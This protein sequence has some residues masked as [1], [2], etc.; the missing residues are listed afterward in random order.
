MLAFQCLVHHLL[1][2]LGSICLPRCQSI[3]YNS[4]CARVQHNIHSFRRTP[5]ILTL[6]GY[7]RFLRESF[8]SD[9]RDKIYSVLG[10]LTDEARQVYTIVPSYAPSNTIAEVYIATAIANLNVNGNP[11]LLVNISGRESE[12]GLP[13]WVPDWSQPRDRTVGN[14]YTLFKAG[15]GHLVQAEVLEDGLELKLHGSLIDAIE[16]IRPVDFGD[17]SGVLTTWENL[18]VH[19]LEHKNHLHLLDTFYRTLTLDT[20]RTDTGDP[21]GDPKDF[22]RVGT[23]LWG[24]S[25][26]TPKETAWDVAFSCHVKRQHTRF[27][28]TARSRG[29]R[30]LH[31]VGFQSAIG[32]KKIRRTGRALPP[33][34]PLLPA[35]HD[36]WRGVQAGR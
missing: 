5:A 25:A 17:A 13:T 24:S 30:H 26:E 34:R 23:K 3:F 27:G 4:R 9:P 19:R 22:R 20:W 28:T 8:A 14:T 10:M 29:R 2:N 36:V 32:G 7:L 31:S 15:I 12:N 18:F 6:E 16:A 11:K 21:H 33:H 35:R 1:Q